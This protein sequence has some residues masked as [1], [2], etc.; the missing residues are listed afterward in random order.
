MLACYTV[1]VEWN[2]DF[3]A[4]Q[5]PQYQSTYQLSVLVRRGIGN[6]NHSQWFLTMFYITLYEGK[7]NGN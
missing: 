3:H 2:R 1:L 7:K 5:R 4:T 6:L